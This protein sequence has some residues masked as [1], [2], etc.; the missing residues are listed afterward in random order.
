MSTDEDMDRSVIDRI[1]SLGDASGDKIAAALDK[2]ADTLDQTTGGG[3][4]ALTAK[5]D[6]AVFGAVGKAIDVSRA[7]GQKAKDVV[8]RPE[9]S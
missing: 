6:A 3:T 9:Q 4:S 7:V 5:A 8:S 2:V 1:A